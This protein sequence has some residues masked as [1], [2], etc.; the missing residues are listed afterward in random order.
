VTEVTPTGSDVLV[1]RADDDF[2]IQQIRLVGELLNRSHEIDLPLTTRRSPDG[3]P[4]Y[5]APSV[6]TR[7][8]E[9]QAGDVVVYRLIV[10]DNHAYEARRQSTTRRC[11]LACRGRFENRLRRFRPARSPVRQALL[12][13]EGMRDELHAGRN[14]RSSVGVACH[15]GEPPPLPTRAI[16][17]RRHRRV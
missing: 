1:A 3:A 17:H 13:Q 2:G 9:A 11:Y 15:W 8:V 7:S 6:G 4:G 5:R 10:T 14:A 12:D 16:P